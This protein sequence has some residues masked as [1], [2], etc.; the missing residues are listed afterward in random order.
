MLALDRLV[1]VKGQRVLDY[2][3]YAKIDRSELFWTCMV[4]YTRWSCIE[5]EFGVIEMYNICTCFC[6]HQ[7]HA[8]GDIHAGDSHR[9]KRALK[10]FHLGL[11]HRARR[12][13]RCESVTERGA[14]RVTWVDMFGMMSGDG[15][16]C[17]LL[18]AK[19]A[20]DAFVQ[21]RNGGRTG[22]SLAVLL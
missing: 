11:E 15:V 22:D 1:F 8:C 14:D 6:C 19:T 21:F 9:I 17:C 13:F 3:D 18:T 7:C 10:N 12:P 20:G 16:L 4:V 2:L 5:S